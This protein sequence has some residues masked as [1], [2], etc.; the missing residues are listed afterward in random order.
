MGELRDLF[1]E[2]AEKLYGDTLGGSPSKDD[3][4][5]QGTASNGGIEG[6]I[7]AEIDE[8][9]DPASVQLF[10]PIRLDVQCGMAISLWC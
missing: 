2:Y 1:T 4:S 6:E 5:F 10:T 8:L 3:A 7:Q 9:H